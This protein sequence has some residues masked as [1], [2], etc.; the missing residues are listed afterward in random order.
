MLRAPEVTTRVCAGPTAAMAITCSVLRRDL[1]MSISLLP[2]P[3]SS[4]GNSLTAKAIQ[5]V[6][7]AFVEFG[8][9]AHR[10]GN[11]MSGAGDGDNALGFGRGD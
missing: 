5:F 2:L 10:K 8:Q 1:G 9:L 3:L 7:F 11:Q 6:A 4:S